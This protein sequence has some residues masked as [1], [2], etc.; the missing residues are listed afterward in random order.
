MWHDLQFGIE[1]TISGSV[2]FETSGDPTANNK[3]ISRIE[4]F[5]PRMLITVAINT[6][7]PFLNVL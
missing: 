4:A 7:G 2:S 3:N 5:S 6:G 1:D